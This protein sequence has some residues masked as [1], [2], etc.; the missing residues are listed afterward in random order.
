MLRCM[1]TN[2]FD[3]IVIGAGIAGATSAAALATDHRV[4]LV[5][6]EEA[7][8]YH[9]TGRSAAIWIH[10]YGPP[11]VRVLTG[12]SRKFFENP[13]PGFSD[14]PLLH[15]RAVLFLAPTAQQAHLDRLL[16]EGI[17]LRKLSIDAVRAM[18][19]ALKPDYAAAAAI[20]EDAFDM[21]VAA[22]HQG[23]LRQL[24]ARGGVLSL[25]SRTGSIERIGG[26]WHVHTSVGGVFTAP[27][28]VNCAG[29]WGDEVARQAGVAPLRLVPKRRTGCV[30]DPAPWQAENWPM[31]NDVDHTWYVRPEARTKLMV[32]PADETDITP[33]DVQPDE[34]DVAIAVDR[35][36]QAMDIEVRR[37]E[38]SWAGLRTFTPD[39][40][41]AFG[42]DGTAEG[43]F[44]CVG[45]G[46]YGIQTS[47]AAGTLVADLVSGRDP[48]AAAAILPAIDPRR[49]AT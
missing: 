17:G 22:L 41:L 36:Q 20:E 27:V 9:S 18:V 47:P 7:A 38:H 21:D 14:T 33:H 24:R 42:W 34:L 2:E 11:D 37:V 44:W 15:Q 39:R 19:P 26:V 49:F 10:N 23:F 32:S 45:Q 1:E 48:G 40:S 28:V 25:R 5:E 8:G 3:V 31:I 12:L 43:F 13:P 46:G 35:M 16:G 30:I 4:A 29:A 6:A